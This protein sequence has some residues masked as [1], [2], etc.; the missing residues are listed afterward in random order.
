VLRWLRAAAV[1][2]DGRVRTCDRGWRFVFEDYALA[3]GGRR[4]PTL[5]LAVGVLGRAGEDGLAFSPAVALDEGGWHLSVR[6]IDGPDRGLVS[7]G[8]VN[9]DR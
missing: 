6:S 9:D 1:V 4:F 8:T 2:S 5:P 3:L 7:V